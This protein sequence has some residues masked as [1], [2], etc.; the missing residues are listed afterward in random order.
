MGTHDHGHWPCHEDGVAMT[1]RDLRLRVRALLAPRRVEQELDEELAFHIERE[2]QK[3]VASGLSLEDAGAR[4]RALFGSTSR[5]AEECR[6]ARGTAFVETC[7]GDVV[8][9]LRS[10][11]RTPTVTLTIVGTVALGLGLVASVFTVFNDF[12]FRVDAVRDPDSLFAVERTTSSDSAARARFTLR[13]YEAL[14][15]ETDVFS[16]VFARLPDITSR[17]DGRMMEGHIVT[18]NFFQVLGVDAAL[19]RTLTP[20]DDMRPAGRPVIVLSHNGWSRLFAS[21]PKVVGRSVIVNGF[22]YEIVGVTPEGFRG[23]DVFLPDYWA[24]LSLVAQFR[25]WLAGREDNVGIDVVGRL[26]PGLSEATARAR[27]AVWASGGTAAIP[28]DQRTAAI[29]LQPRRTAM[30][31]SPGVLLGFSPLFFAFGLILMIGCAN[32]ANLLLARAV[33]RQREIGIR[34]SLGASRRRVIRQLLTESLLL[35]L[36]SAVCAFAI[37]RVV[38][39][40]T[41]SVLMSTMPLELAEFLSLAAPGTDWRAAVFLVVAAIISTVLFGLVPALQATRLDLVPTVRAQPSLAMIRG[42]SFGVPGRARSVL[43]VVQVIVSALLLISAGVF[44]RSA[45]RASTVDPG[46][47]IADTIIVEIV[48][49]PFRTAMVAAVSAE[50]SVAAVA[51]SWPEPLNRPRAAFGSSAS[52][53]AMADR[54]ASAGAAAGRP[55]RLPVAYRF[56]SPEYFSVLDIGV[57]RGRAFTQAEASSNAAVAVV[58]E[59]TARQIWPNGD[60]VAQVLRLDPDPDSE[61]RRQGEPA[62]PSQTFIVVGVVRDVAGFR[63]AGYS[64]AGVYVPT[65]PATA[66]TA[67]I[68]RVHGDPELARRALLERL[69]SIDPNMGMVMTM[70][71]LGRLETYPLQVAFWLTVVLGGLA[72]LLTLSGIFSVLSYLVEQRTKEIGVRIALGATTGNVTRLVLRQSL[73]QVGVGLIVG[74]GLACGLA[75]LLMS[76]PAAAPA[77]VLS[78]PSYMAR[79]GGIVDVFDPLAYAASLLCIVTACALAAS[80]PALRAARIDP[81]ATLR[82]E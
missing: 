82:Q 4:A 23:R 54:S 62:L 21:D 40:V 61:S 81:I 50:P 34:L 55:G 77:T 72:L 12:V 25:P 66:E 67:L 41:T 30:P 69:T 42:A 57:L 65:G 17:I 36:A 68:A 75:T 45:L 29:R 74:G 76:T 33:S 18:G 5:A 1:W 7:A 27:L 35:A 28:V 22:R 24:P 32:V 14:R 44:L 71:T 48:N 8:Y 6:D 59:G 19:G 3:H 15:R 58:S 49:E 79:I 53:E 47:R 38:L 31:L 2:T 13:Q 70:R 51:A 11:R 73:R 80:I 20:D 56:V 60:A 78:T 63:I 26:K 10:L 16:D 52:A 64:E 46:L 37:S 9:A 43:I 39:D